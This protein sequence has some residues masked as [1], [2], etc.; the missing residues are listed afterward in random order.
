M[1]DNQIGDNLKRDGR[2][3]CMPTR[4]EGAKTYNTAKRMVGRITCENV[5]VSN[6]RV[7]DDATCVC[8]LQK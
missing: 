6:A 2:R 7:E 3:A 1:Y 4:L 5:N 8:D